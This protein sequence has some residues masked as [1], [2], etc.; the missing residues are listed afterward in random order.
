MERAV[1]EIE[2]ILGVI[3]KVNRVAWNRERERAGRT[4]KEGVHT[5]M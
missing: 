2:Q 3:Q 1:T 5:G 4:K